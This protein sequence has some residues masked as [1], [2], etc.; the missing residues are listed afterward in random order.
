ML[1]Q[2]LAPTLA[3][4][5]TRIVL[6]FHGNRWSAQELDDDS[7]RLANG[8]Q[9]LGVGQIDRVAVLLPN[10]PETIHAYLACF[11]ANFVIV[12]LDYRHHAA[13]IRYA[14]NHSGAETLIVHHDR[15]ED[16][17]EEGVLAGIQNVVTVK[18]TADH[19]YLTFD[20]ILEGASGTFAEQSFEPDDL[21]VMIYT[22]GTT[23]RPKGVTLTRSA[24]IAGIKKYLAHVAINQDD[25]ALIAAPIT[26]PMALRCQLLPVLHAGGCVSLIE[27]F[28][29]DIYVSALQQSPRKTFL[30]LL[31]G[32]LSKLLSHEK[33]RECDFSALRICLAG[34]DRVPNKLHEAF[35]EITGVPLTEQCGSSEVGAYALNPPFGRK[36]PGSIGLPMYGAQVCIV[37]PDGNDAP[38]GQ[39]GEIVV[40]SPLMMEGYWNDTALTRK[41]LHNGWVRTGDLGRFD[42]DGYLWF[43]GRKKDIIVCGGSNVSPMEV[44]SILLSHPSVGE[45]CVYGVT[46]IDGIEQVHACVTT[47]ANTE[48]ATEETL[49]KFANEHLADYMVPHRIKYIDEMPRKGAGKVDRERLRMREETGMEDL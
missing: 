26:R 24:M 34:G 32:A 49:I 46:E 38:A 25:V 41:T 12:P 16:L 5:P 40:S 42:Q 7:T 13:Q 14:L 23:A 19:E 9:K 20:K 35:Q 2:L 11:K 21:S 4:D 28:D 6:E 33:I 30:A 45:A 47:Q 27:Q 8:L 31:P 18:S 37:T 39:I 1:H 36:K 15:I 17:A 29:V 3:N 43:M 22:S 44:E 48:Q 10:C